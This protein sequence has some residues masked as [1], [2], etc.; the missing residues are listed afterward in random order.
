M[1]S[2]NLFK[3]GG[4]MVKLMSTLAR[5]LAGTS[6]NTFRGS[7]FLHSLFLMWG[8]RRLVTSKSS[9]LKIFLHQEEKKS[10]R[11]QAAGN[12]ESTVHKVIKTFFSNQLISEFS[13]F[14]DNSNKASYQVHGHSS[15]S[16][17]GSDRI[18]RI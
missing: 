18:V 13:I 8:V 9:K 14:V 6:K 11:L 7:W 1:E 4:V 5:F 2:S 10:H 17:S 15:P 16:L 12:L 3:V